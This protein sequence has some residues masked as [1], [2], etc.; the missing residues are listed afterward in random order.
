MATDV[1]LTGAAYP[2][3]IHGKEY[4][5]R[6][7]TD[8]DHAELDAYVQSELMRVA[9]ET[10]TSDMTTEERREQLSAALS[11]V[12]GLSWGS[13]E[14]RRVMSSLKGMT[15]LGWQMIK[16]YQPKLEFEVFY[17][18]L[19]KYNGVERDNSD[20]QDAINKIDETFLILNTSYTKTGE[21]DI[22]AE[23]EGDSAEDSKRTS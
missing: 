9:R 16:H 14:G 3:K 11:I 15:R 1:Q 21:L 18:H 2:L 7:L 19:I 6:T 22:D 20:I 8:K 5:A 17:E 12:E 23:V 10:L 4:S 13:V